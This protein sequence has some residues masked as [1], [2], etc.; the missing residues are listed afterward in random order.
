M[1]YA[2]FAGAG[3]NAKVATKLTDESMRNAYNAGAGI[4]IMM[5]LFVWAAGAVV[6]GLLAHFTRGKRELI[7]IESEVR[8]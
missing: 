5:L 6:F 7:E 4:G 3:E 1:V 2:I 8:S